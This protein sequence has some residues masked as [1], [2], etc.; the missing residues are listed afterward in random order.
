MS[1]HDD[2]RFNILKSHF[3]MLKMVTHANGMEMSVISHS[4]HSNAIPA[5]DSA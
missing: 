5:N 2:D 3:H 4:N 1:S